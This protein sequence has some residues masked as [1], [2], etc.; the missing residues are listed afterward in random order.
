MA[1]Y[2]PSQH[3]AFEVVDD[4]CSASVE[5]AAFPG[6]TVV[7]VTSAEITDR[8]LLGFLAGRARAGAH[9]RAACYDLP[10]ADRATGDHDAKGVA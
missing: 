1:L 6:I 2:L 3:I 4:P 8:A 7:R 5:E 9:G 10:A